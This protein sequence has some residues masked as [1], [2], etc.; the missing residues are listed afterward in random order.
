MGD[1][2]K[3]EADAK[4]VKEQEKLAA[5]APKAST[6]AAKDGKSKKKTLA[7]AAEAAS[8]ALTG[9][10]KSAEKKLAAQSAKASD[11]LQTAEAE[12]DEEANGDLEVTAV[13]DEFEETVLP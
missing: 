10:V 13:E 9:N 11:A 1:T 4:F 3:A 5:K 2:K 6:P 7:H 8:S 12:V